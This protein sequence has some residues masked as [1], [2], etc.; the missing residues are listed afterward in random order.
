MSESEKQSGNILIVD[1]DESILS[2]LRATLRREGYEVTTLS[3]PLAALPLLK[4]REF[5]VILSDQQ[6]PNLTGP[7]L[8]AQAQ[9]LQPDATRILITGIVNLNTIVDSINERCLRF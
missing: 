5:A 2:T 9:I 1:D 6:M 4:Q 7:E 3:D 8:L